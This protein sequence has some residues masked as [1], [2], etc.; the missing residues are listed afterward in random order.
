MARGL[1][2]PRIEAATWGALAAIVLM[3]A[4]VVWAYATPRLWQ[5]AAGV[6]GGVAVLAAIAALMGPPS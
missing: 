6:L 1:P 5:A 2:A 4:A 3:P